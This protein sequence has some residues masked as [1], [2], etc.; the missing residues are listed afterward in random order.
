MIKVIHNK[1]HNQGLAYLRYT[2]ERCFFLHFGDRAKLRA[3]ALHS[4]KLTHRAPH[5]MWP[6][7]LGLASCPLFLTAQHSWLH[8]WTPPFTA[9]AL[10]KLRSLDLR[11]FPTPPASGFTEFT[12]SLYS[13]MLRLDPKLSYA[14]L[15]ACLYSR[16][17]LTP[18]HSL[19]SYF[20]FLSS[21]STISPISNC[22]LR[23]ST[24]MSCLMPKPVR[25]NPLLVP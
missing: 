19:E 18:L 4:L 15:P 2:D 17:S 8:L 7:R 12:H 11:L 3:K 20:D 16:T 13:W 10:V 25:P 5:A 14:F 6:P 22:L 21:W 23:V 9:N 24:R 1:Q